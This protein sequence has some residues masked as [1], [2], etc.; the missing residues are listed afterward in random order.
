[1]IFGSLFTGI[2]GF[3]LGL[4][5][6]GLQ[7]AWQCE[8]DDDAETVLKSH[9]P[10][11]VRQRDI[12]G[13]D[14][15]GQQW[16]V[17]VLCG[18]FPCQDV[19]LCGSMAGIDGEQSSLFWEFA[20]LAEET[21]PTW[22]IIEN[23]TGLL[24][25][26]G[27]RDFL[28]VIRALGQRGY[29]CAWRTF[30]VRCFGLPQRRPRVFLVGHLGAWDR[31]ARVLFDAGCLQ[32]DP[33]KSRKKRDRA[34]GDIAPGTPFVFS[35]RIARCKRGLPSAELPTLTSYEESGPHSDS[36]PHVVTPHGIRRLTA[37][38]HERAMGFP[39]DWTNG[40][41]EKRRRALC[42][43]ALAPAIAEWI[44]SRILSVAA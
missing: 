35:P 22:L 16:A 20:R 42:G 21:G 26:N 1:M 13:F 7:C 17:D 18:G 5:R 9:W 6:S 14:G 25:G 11:A 37:L 33:R 24:T 2:G 40:V 12:R 38:E 43:N 32:D 34:T 29:V 4:E 39:D 44:G 28:A 36:K 8:I 3:D 15:A 27:G 31:P 23:V 41:I 30:D 10:D 19:S